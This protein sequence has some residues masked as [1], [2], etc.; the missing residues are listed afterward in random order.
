M[1]HSP[2]KYAYLYW[3]R[4]MKAY[5]FVDNMWSNCWSEYSNLFPYIIDEIILAA[6]QFNGRDVSNALPVNR[7]DSIS[8]FKNFFCGLEAAKKKNNKQ[9]KLEAV[10]FRAQ[11]STRSGTV[12]LLWPH[13]G[14]VISIWK[15]ARSSLI[16]HSSEYMI[17]CIL[18]QKCVLQKK[19]CWWRYSKPI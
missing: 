8:L 17:C 13:G 16:F 2:L 6:A 1:P 5:I 4:T 12:G 19:T 18:F 11:V 15:G 9:H 7:K 3:C 10:L 14:T